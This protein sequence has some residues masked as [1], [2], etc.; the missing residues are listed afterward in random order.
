MI[1]DRSDVTLRTPG[2]DDDAVGERAFALEI[3]E[4]DVDRFVVVETV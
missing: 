4:Q 2:G 1:G 3:D